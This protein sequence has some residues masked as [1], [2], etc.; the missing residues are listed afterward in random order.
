MSMYGSRGVE[1]MLLCCIYVVSLIVI[2]VLLKHV[3]CCC[4]VCMCLF[5]DIMEVFR[6]ASR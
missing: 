3:M 6:S 4:C 1:Y 2:I 5:L